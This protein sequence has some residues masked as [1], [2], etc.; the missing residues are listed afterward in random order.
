MLCPPFFI[1][2][3]RI[4]KQRKTEKS[5]NLKFVQNAV[6]KNQDLVKNGIAETYHR[7]Q[8]RT[9]CETNYGV[10]KQRNA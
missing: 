9:S 3:Q 8:L 10:G 7:L 5:R 1:L 4:E 6:F 2:S